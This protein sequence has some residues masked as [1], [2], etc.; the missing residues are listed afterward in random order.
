MNR[1][2]QFL[3]MSMSSIPNLFDLTG[4][5]AVITGGAGLLGRQHAMAISAFGGMPVILDIDYR[6]ANDVAKEVGGLAF[7]CD[8]TTSSSIGTTLIEVVSAYRHV[9]ILVNNVSCNTNI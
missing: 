7:E 1:K 5:V 9:D 4:K 3:G 6:D 2:T 8:V